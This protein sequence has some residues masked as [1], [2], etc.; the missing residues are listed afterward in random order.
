[1]VDARQDSTGG[2]PFLMSLDMDQLESL[3]KTDYSGSM[4]EQASEG[5]I[6]AIIEVMLEKEKEDPSGRFPDT[7]KAW[8]DFQT[9]Y[10]VPGRKHPHPSPVPAVPVPLPSQAATRPRRSR[11][12]LRWCAL[13]A[14]VIGLFM[15]LLVAAQAAGLDV[16]GSMARWT[17]ET[18]HFVTAPANDETA[19]LRAVLRE[20]GFP[21]EYAPTWVPEGFCAEE[22]VV[23]VSKN[24]KHISLHFSDRNK[25]F[26][27][28]I[29][30]F[31]S[32][33]HLETITYE[34]DFHMVTSYNNGHQL[35]YIFENL[36]NSMAT[37]SDGKTFALEICGQISVSDIKSIIDSIGG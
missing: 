17:D 23:S 22:P 2:Y 24:V 9:Y 29:T 25:S 6:D 33:E 18:F 36:E 28:V 16:F 10:N 21:E 3:L 8:A 13:V 27:I 1:M 14:A 15:A 11:R 4:S 30:Q 20:Q 19:E 7:E 5:L 37:W 35:F 26:R 12:L 34:K 31:P 32:N